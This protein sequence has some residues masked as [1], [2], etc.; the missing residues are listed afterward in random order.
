M[1]LID[2]LPNVR[3]RYT[4]GAN[5]SKYTWFNVG[6]P[7]EVLYKPA[8]FD[9]L[10]TFLQNTPKQI[11]ITILGVGS[12]LLVRDGGIDGVVIRLGRAFAT[13]EAVDQTIAAGAG[14]LDQNVAQVALENGLTG[15]EFLSGIP[16]TIGGA[17]R[18]NAGAYQHEIKD[19]LVSATAIDRDGIVR[20]LQPDDF[21]FTYR[22]CKIDPSWIFTHAVLQAQPG[23]KTEIHANMAKIRQ[24]RE[25]SQPVKGKTGGSTF[26][27]P[28]GEKAW[29]L[30]DQAGCRGLTVGGAQVSEKHCNFLIN[31]GNA[32]AHDIEKL[33]ETVRE[34]VFNK[35]N[36]DLQWE[37]AR[38][39][40]PAEI[41]NNTP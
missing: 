37:I 17:L 30:I 9:D 8:D 4:A 40:K 27:N 1:S 20:Q 10:Q 14:A 16:G 12:N 39:G 15:L 41:S 18:M 11:P 22:H 5:L 3:G 36:V 25:D 19:V 32:T 35:T 13:I 38:I 21:G 2:Q 24:Q 23:D 29:A 6:G 34:R 33:G 7:A 26:K 31:T 28:E